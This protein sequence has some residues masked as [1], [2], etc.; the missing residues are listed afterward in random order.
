[1]SNHLMLLDGIPMIGQQQNIKKRLQIQIKNETSENNTIFNS[2]NLNKLKVKEWSHV[3][4]QLYVCLK[5][6]QSTDLLCLKPWM[7]H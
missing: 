7:E 3:K 6:E 1:M 4:P 5:D 2:N